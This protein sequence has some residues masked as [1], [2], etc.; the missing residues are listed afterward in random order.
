MKSSLFNELDKMSY[1]KYLMLYP[2]HEKLGIKLAE[3]KEN[4]NK[5]GDKK[6]RVKRGG[7]DLRENKKTFWTKTKN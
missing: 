5:A 1:E 3:Y 6:S 2:F 7:G 4:L